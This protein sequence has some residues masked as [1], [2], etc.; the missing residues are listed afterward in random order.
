MGHKLISSIPKKHGA[1]LVP[2]EDTVNCV[3]TLRIFA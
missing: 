3:P 2:Q 1:N